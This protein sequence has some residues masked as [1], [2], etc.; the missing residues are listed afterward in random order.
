MAGPPRVEDN[1]PRW[2]VIGFSGHRHLGE[3][4]GAAA[5]AVREVIDKLASRWPRIAGI[6]SAA[7][8]GDT[9]FAEEMLRRDVP[10]SIVLPFPCE[11]FKTDFEAEPPDAWPRSEEI[12]RRAVELDVVHQ[13]DADVGMVVESGLQAEQ[14]RALGKERD[15][16]AYWETTLRTVD[17]S[18][19][20]LAIWN[21][22][23]GK[24]AGGTADAVKY[25]RQIR[26]PL[27]IFDPETGAFV[28]ERLAA[29]LPDRPCS[30]YKSD[31]PREIVKEYFSRLSTKASSHGPEARK[32]IRKYVYFH[33]A[34][35]ASG[36]ISI[37]IT[38]SHLL[39]LVPAAVEVGLLVCA[40]SMLKNRGK[41]YREWLSRRVET[42][43][44]RSFL[45]TWN[46]R[47]HP[48]IG[49]EP[50][51]ALPNQRR[52]FAELRFL[53]RLDK[54]PTPPF[55]DVRQDYLEGRVQ[56]QLKYFDEKQKAAKKTYA[57]YE[58]WSKTCTIGAAL[59]ALAVLTLLLT[60]ANHKFLHVFEF[61]GI[62]L[63]LGSSA[64]GLLM[65]TEEASRRVTRYDQMKAAIEQL[66][67]VVEAAPTWESLARAATQ[68]EEELLQELV[69][70]ESF[71]R[72]TEH[73]H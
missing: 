36:A 1:L 32:I 7:S 67:P 58:W 71:V 8:G 4:A 29:L 61:L 62:V 66:K 17:R 5:N 50:R 2:L 44:C 20:F 14:Q 38:A 43:I 9:L 37:F 33:L 22:K 15:A 26:L 69:E 11:R 24:G 27:I 60:D 35:S 72:N 19:V 23:P 46:I 70:W 40:A 53:R 64:A 56:H 48:I 54:S 42:E 47:R 57:K 34:A 63:P 39:S 12:I 13:L 28:E 31:N 52:L 21:G 41:H 68:V 25:A 59:A 10:L 18:D 6:S 51:A 49:H 55:E 65:I 16:K 45:H 3:H 73:L 30:P